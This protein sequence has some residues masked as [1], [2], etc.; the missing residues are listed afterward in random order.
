MKTYSRLLFVLM[1]FVPCV[2]VAQPNPDPQP[3]STNHL[4]IGAPS[5][6]NVQ[7]TGADII[8]I[9]CDVVM[10]MVYDGDEPMFYWD[11]TTYQ[12]NY[13]GMSPFLD[14]DIT[15]PDVVLTP[16]FNHALVV[17]EYNGR[18]Y[19]SVW[20]FDGGQSY[21]ELQWFNNTQYPLHLQSG[22]NPN[23]DMD[24]GWHFAITWHSDNGKTDEIWAAV[25]EF[26]SGGNPSLNLSDPVVIDRGRFPDVAIYE[27]TVTFT[28]LR[29][30]GG[31]PDYD[32]V[33]FQE[34]KTN[35]E[36][37]NIVS[38]HVNLY[39]T[40]NPPFSDYGRPRIA[41]P[42]YNDFLFYGSEFF[43][44][45]DY[46]EYDGFWQYEI[47]GYVYH[48]HQLSP[49]RKYNENDFFFNL[50]KDPV[51][52]YHGDESVVAWTISCPYPPDQTDRINIMARYTY[53]FNG[54]Y[55]SY[56]A[57]LVNQYLDD[58]QTIS[59]IAGRRANTVLYFLA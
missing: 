3:A 48:N 42:F 5:I 30:I 19:L 6:D 34:S 57:P 7:N 28:Y 2:L 50:N 53:Y 8:T 59:S 40:A 47:V 52:T 54:F 32:W 12:G 23:I 29:D 24:F 9:D 41:A 38:S 20:E 15:D 49:V 26:S 33:Y 21:Y 18:I 45:V 46:R 31:G 27:D 39:N 58:D 14:Q 1:A 22:M 55:N 25:G 16:D 51:V 36:N 56:D 35:I 10:V 13:T 17:Y 43:V 37:H 4:L 11:I 44:T